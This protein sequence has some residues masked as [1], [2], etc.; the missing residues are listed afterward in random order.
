T[1]RNLVRKIDCLISDNIASEVSALV[2]TVDNLPL[3]T[4]DNP[5][6]VREIAKCLELEVEIGNLKKQLSGSEQQCSQIEKHS[7]ELELKFQKYRDCFEHP[8]VCDNTQSQEYNAFFEINKL[9]EQLQGKDNTINQLQI[10]ET[11]I[12]QLKDNITSLNIQ[13]NAY[14]IECK[15]LSQRYE[16]LAKFNMHS[17][18]QLTGRISALTSENAT[19]KAGNKGKPLSP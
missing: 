7:V 16:E 8:S 15:T 2:L 18:V 17:R 5:S 1:N 4:Q 6:C 10:L 11:E 13:L 12:T 19:L 14:K 9:K 3:E